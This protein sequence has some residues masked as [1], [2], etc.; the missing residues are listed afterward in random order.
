MHAHTCTHATTVR[1]FTRCINTLTC[2]LVVFPPHTYSHKEH[3]AE[4]SVCKTLYIHICT[5][6]HVETE[7]CRHPRTS[8]RTCIQ[9]RS[10][11]APYS[12]SICV[13]TLTLK[14]VCACVCVLQIFPGFSLQP[15]L[16]ALSFTVKHV[17]YLEAGST[18]SP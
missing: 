11:G 8:T 14:C 5:Q 17:R 15:S 3:I 1:A 7:P 12:L 13:N 6:P 18:P 2:T 10:Q 16:S 9:H 4:G